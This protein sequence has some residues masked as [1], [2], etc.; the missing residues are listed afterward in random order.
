M[1]VQFANN[2][3]KKIPLITSHRNW[4]SIELF[5]SN[6]F[7]IGQHAVLLPILIGLV[8]DDNV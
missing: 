8:R 3:I 6:Y 4:Q 7:Q 2:Q 5:S 1:P